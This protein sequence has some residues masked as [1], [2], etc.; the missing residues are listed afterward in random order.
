[1]K[2]YW[3]HCSEVDHGPFL[4]AQ[5]RLPRYPAD[6]EPPVPRLCVC[7]DVPSCFAARLFLPVP[8]HVYVTDRKRSAVRPRGVWDACITGERWIVDPVLLVRVRTVNPD[9]QVDA[10]WWA[11]LKRR[12]TPRT[13]VC[14]LL[15]AAL[16][17][18]E[19]VRKARRMADK[20]GIDETYLEERCW[21][22][23]G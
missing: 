7:P 12:S 1:M 18:G 5:R 22:M 8:V 4:W 10:R 14:Q 9:L 21:N 11:K 20:L 16:A 13:R 6:G 17:L 23:I 2:R 15:Q 19:E 3:Y